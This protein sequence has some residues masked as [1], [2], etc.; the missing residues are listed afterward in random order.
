MQ[1]LAQWLEELGMSE[2]SQ[3]FAE[4]DIDFAILVELTD[5]DLEKIGVKSLGHRRKNCAR[6]PSWTGAKLLKNLLWWGQPQRLHRVTPP[7]AA[8]SPWCFRTWSVR[9]RCRRVWTL[10]TF[11]RSFRPIR[12]VS[13]IFQRSGGFVAKYM[14]DGVLVYSA[15]R[16]RWGQT[17]GV[18]PVETVLK[19]DKLTLVL[20]RGKDGN[21]VGPNSGGFSPVETV[22]RTDKLT[23]VLEREKDGKFQAKTTSWDANKVF[24]PGDQLRIEVVS[25]QLVLSRW[26][27][28]ARAKQ[29]RQRVA[30]PKAVAGGLPPRGRLRRGSKRECANHLATVLGSRPS[31]RAVCAMVGPGDHGSR[32]SWKTSRN[33]SPPAPHSGAGVAVHAADVAR[34][35]GPVVANG[36]WCGRCHLVTGSPRYGGL[37]KPI[38]TAGC[39]V[40]TSCNGDRAALAVSTTGQMGCAIETSCNAVPARR[41]LRQ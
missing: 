11:A 2:Y 31:A 7:S 33:R 21:Q 26:H 19:T 35:S 22:L 14:G 23:H 9:Q 24:L 27:S 41:R 17:Q 18:S 37:N 3:R 30:V 4:N 39:A 16:S 20:E 40:K 32:G 34:M 28:E 13:L 29:L 38:S 15:T 36:P 8:K 6:S 5:Q 12:S 10:R 25:G 1:D